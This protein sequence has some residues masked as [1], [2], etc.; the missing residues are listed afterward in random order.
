MIM[1][2]LKNHV[3]NDVLKQSVIKLLTLTIDVNK[4]QVYHE[5]Y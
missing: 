5:E 2:V 4:S 3:K 1:A